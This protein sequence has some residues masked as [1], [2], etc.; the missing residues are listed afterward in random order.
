MNKAKSDSILA[1]VLA[2]A[3]VAAGAILLAATRWGIGVS[4]DSVFYLSAA[5]N[6]L[7]GLGL[8]RLGGGGEVIPLTHF[9][10][11]YPLLL[12]AGSW[13]SPLST[14][15]VARWM[16]AFLFT[17]LVTISGLIVKK[18]TNSAIAG[19]ATGVIVASSPVLLEVDAWA[20][21]EGLYLVC[22]LGALWLLA[23]YLSDDSWGHLLGAALVTGAAYATRYV[24]AS[25]LAT[26][27]IVVWLA[28]NRPRTARLVR[29]C[30]YG[31]GSAIPALVWMVRNILLT[32]MTTNRTLL[33]HPIGRDKLSEAAH[34]LASLALPDGLAFRLRL[35]VT[36]IA[37][38]ALAF[39]LVEGMVAGPKRPA[40]AAWD[41]ASQ[42]AGVFV[43]H[44]FIYTALLVVSLSFLD[45]STRLDDRILSPIWLL[46][47]VLAGLGAGRWLSAG[48]RPVWPRWALAAVWVGAGSERGRSNLGPGQFGLCSRPGFQQSGLGDLAHAGLGA[49]AG[50]RTPRSLR[51]KLSPCIT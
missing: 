33:F 30:V 50:R 45:A 18:F 5:D 35:A 7:H 48:A 42:L 19:A 36:L 49:D 21:S 11:L 15:A 23:A 10:P 6:L 40:P 31:V 22:L 43:L 27:L 29:M 13:L 41:G 26:G 16:A 39:L 25:L 12:A 47:I 9:P 1:V 17:G 20:M 34:T 51:T 37:L 4:Y 46:I 2:V 3:G 14:S 8:S 28:G 38:A 32:G 24:G 44:A